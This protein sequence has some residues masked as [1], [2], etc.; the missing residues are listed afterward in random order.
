MPLAPVSAPVFVLFSR[1]DVNLILF[2]WLV[3]RCEPRSV[4]VLLSIVYTLCVFIPYKGFISV[5][6]FYFH[7]PKCENGADLPLGADHTNL[8]AQSDLLDPLSACPRAVKTHPLKAFFGWF[9]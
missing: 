1:T 7:I 9:T 8:N 6:T 3:H 2:V 4:D 5:F